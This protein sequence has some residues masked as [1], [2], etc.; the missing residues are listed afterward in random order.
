MHSTCVLKYMY[1]YKYIYSTL[2]T[3]PKNVI[4]LD[5]GKKNST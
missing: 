3:G 1:K 4:V 5:W 2:L